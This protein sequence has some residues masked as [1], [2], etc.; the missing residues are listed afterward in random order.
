MCGVFTAIACGSND[1]H[2]NPAVTLGFAVR[3]GAYGKFLL[4]VSAQLLGAVVGAALVWLQYLPHWKETSDTGLKLGVFCTAPA[5]RNTVTNLY[6][7]SDCNIRSGFRCGRDFLK[8]RLGEWPCRRAWAHTWWEAWSGASAFLGGS[9][10]YAINPARDFGA[11][12]RARDSD[13]CGQGRFRL[14]LRADSDCRSA[15]GR[16]H[17]QGLL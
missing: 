10:G 5:I 12:S 7:R 8:E 4:Y 16:L 1:A 3:A 9:T 14:G 17:W 11:P 2:L 13:D 15:R 6:Q